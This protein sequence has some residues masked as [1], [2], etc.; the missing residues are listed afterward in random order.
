MTGD[1]YSLC[2]PSKL[3]SKKFWMLDFCNINIA[4]LVKRGECQHDAECPDNRACIS[5]QCL[6]PCTLH[7]PCGKNA[8]C[9]TRGHRPVCRCPK[10]WA[11]DPHTE[12]Y[13]CMF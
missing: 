11:G 9:D 1:P 6:D 13:T 8:Q 12:C 10:G 3:D 4:I 5:N 7:D 2:V